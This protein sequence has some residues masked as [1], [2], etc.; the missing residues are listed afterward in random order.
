MR[1]GLVTIDFALGTRAVLDYAALLAESLHHSIDVLSV[2]ELAPVAQLDVQQLPA[3]VEPVELLARDR[4]AQQLQ[5]FIA[6]GHMS[7]DVRVHSRLEAGDV[8][9]GI[10]QLAEREPYDLIVMGTH[11]RSGLS[12]FLMGSV[13]EKVMRRAPCP[14]MTV[15]AGAMAAPS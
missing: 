15:R 5:E 2:G 13:A 14:V 8:Y 12:H 9:A 6:A 4:V 3:P 10:L 11:G 1:R 7:D